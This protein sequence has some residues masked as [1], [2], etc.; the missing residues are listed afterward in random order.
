MPMMRAVQIS[1]PGGELELV[2]REIPEPKE[3]EVLIKIEACGVCHGDAI[4]KEGS[5]PVLR[6]LNRKKSAY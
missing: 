4:V 2:Q 6:N 3:N 1:N 5:F